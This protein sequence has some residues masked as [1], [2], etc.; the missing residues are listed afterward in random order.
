MRTSKDVNPYEAPQ[1]P[2]GQPHSAPRRHIAYF[3]AEAIILLAVSALTL[4]LGQLFR[5]AGIAVLV[6]SLLIL[7]ISLRRSSRPTNV[8]AFVVKWGLVFVFAA[9]AIIAYIAKRLNL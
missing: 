2:L 4:D 6:Q 1:T 5:I 3:V 9:T 7:L 8:D